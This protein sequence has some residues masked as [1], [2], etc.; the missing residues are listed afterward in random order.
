MVMTNMYTEITVDDAAPA[1][2]RK[3]VGTGTA[4]CGPPFQFIAKSMNALFTR[5]SEYTPGKLGRAQ[6][7]PNDTMPVSKLLQIRPPPESPYDLFISF[8][9]FYSGVHYLKSPDKCLVHHLNT[10]HRSFPET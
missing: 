7:Y 6:P 2:G 9:F 10:Q 5:T 3:V 4:D 8:C 1:D